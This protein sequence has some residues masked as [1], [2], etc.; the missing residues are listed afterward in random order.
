MYQLKQTREE[1]VNAARENFANED[2]LQR[3]AAVFPTWKLLAEGQPVSPERIAKTLNRPV[4][5]VR[6]DLGRVE[7]F[8][9]FGYD[10][11]SNIVNFFGLE[12]D[13]TAHR[14]D[15][16]GQELFAG[17]AVDSLFIPAFVGKTATVESECP[18]SGTE[19]RLTV[20]PEQVTDVEPC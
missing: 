18:V 10:E 5:E 19:I 14:L 6:D 9:F 7:E 8:G 1:L 15:I 3:L 20:T 17:C 12:L 13:R 16:G 2:L 4:D 11:D